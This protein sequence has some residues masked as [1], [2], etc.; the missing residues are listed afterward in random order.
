[1]GKLRSPIEYNNCCFSVLVECEI[2][3][4]KERKRISKHGVVFSS[5]NLLHGV[6]IVG[7][8]LVV[9]VLHHG[10]ATDFDLI[11]DPRSLRVCNSP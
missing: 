1:M 6:A 8:R 5:A 2:T 7:S 4:S 3:T 10:P 11:L 9:D